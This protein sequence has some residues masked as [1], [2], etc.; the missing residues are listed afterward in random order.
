MSDFLGR[1]RYE[2]REH[3]QRGDRSGCEPGRMRTAEGEVRVQVPQVRDSAQAY[4]S[5]LMEFV[6]G[7]SAGLEYLVVQMYTR[8]LSTRDIEEAL[9]DPVSGETLLSKSAASALTERLWQDYLAFC[10]RGPKRRSNKP[11]GACT[12]RQCGRR[13]V[14]WPTTSSSATGLCIPRRC[15]GFRMI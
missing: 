10:Q 12:M 9:R 15:S 3:K 11:C 1:E 5:R 2:Q 4:R 13:L 7:N 8:G 14:C 6:R